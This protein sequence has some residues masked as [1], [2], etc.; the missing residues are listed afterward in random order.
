MTDYATLRTAMVDCQVRPSD[1]TKFPIISAMLAA[2]REVY[3]PAGKRE[4]AYVGAHV[5]LTEGRVVLDPRVLA[6]MLDALDIGRND[7]VLLVGCGLGYSA[8]VIARMA[9]MVVA[10]EEDT[11]LAAE[12]EANLA[13]ESVDNAI[14]VSGALAQGAAKHGP[15]DAI[16]FGGAVEQIPS[17]ILDQLKDGGKI[18]ALFAEGAAGQCR[19]GVKTGGKV[20]WRNVFDATAPVLPGFAKQKAFAL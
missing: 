13:A 6:K 3:V 9:E 14:V 5:P 7:L 17:A 10:V 16:M 19:A 4:V 1:V 2:R 15:Y 8:D 12:A 20:A 11:T 18:C